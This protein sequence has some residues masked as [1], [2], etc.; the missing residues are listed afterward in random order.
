MNIYT[1][2]NPYE[3]TDLCHIMNKYG[4]DKSKLSCDGHHNYSTLYTKLFDPVKHLQLNIFELGIG[5]NNILLPSNMGING[6]PGASLRGWRDFF[7]NSQIHGA[8]ID[9]DILFTEE[10]IKTYYCDQLNPIIIKNMWDEIE[11]NFD[12]IIEDGLHTFEANKCFFENSIH[13]LKKDGVYII[14]DIIHVKDYYDIIN[15]W[16]TLY[17]LEINIKQIEGA[18]NYDN[19]IIIIQKI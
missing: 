9:K 19:N 6:K 3:I 4:S 14:E 8:D 10:R 16:K 17:N 2:F 12:I 7:P 18:N 5:T 1:N 13:K 15:K 11:C